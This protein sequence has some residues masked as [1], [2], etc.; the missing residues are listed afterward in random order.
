MLKSF[1]AYISDYTE[2]NQHIICAKEGNAIGMAI[3]YHLAT[4]H[5]P[6]VYMQNSVLGN[7]INPL[8]SLDDKEVY[9]IPILMMIGW[10]GE[11]GT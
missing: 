6:F 3:G 9:S 2:L 1:C 11:P 7:A 5:S 4:G 10:G 8:L